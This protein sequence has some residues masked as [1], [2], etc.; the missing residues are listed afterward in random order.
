VSLARNLVQR[1]VLHST[2]APVGFTDCVQVDA[3]L[4]NSKATR[5]GLRTLIRELVLNRTI[6]PRK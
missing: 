1:L 5:F 6:F 3:I 2:D 4:E